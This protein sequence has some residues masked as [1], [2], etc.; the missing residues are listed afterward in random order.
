MRLCFSV[1]YAKEHFK[2]PVGNLCQAGDWRS[3]REYREMAESKILFSVRYLIKSLYMCVSAP[4][5]GAH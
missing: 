3:M 5:M 4:E 2:L 1:N